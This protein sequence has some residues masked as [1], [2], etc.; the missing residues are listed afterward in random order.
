MFSLLFSPIYRGLAI[1]GASL[2][3]LASVY[4]KGRKDA[5]DKA[6]LTSLRET[7]DAITK[8]NEARNRSAAESDRGGLYNDD[9]F[10]RK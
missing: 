9:G 10:K 2:V 7:Q 8:A 3:F 6:N 1:A 5:S 4:A